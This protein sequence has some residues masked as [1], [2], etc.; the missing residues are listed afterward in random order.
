VEREILKDESLEA[1]ELINEIDTLAIIKKADDI[2]KKEDSL[3]IKVILTIISMIFIAF[4]LVTIY[5]GGFK[6]F[7]ITEALIMWVS[8][9]F[10]FTLMKKY[11]V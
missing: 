1:L 10:L 5:I 11:Y 2:S 3:R 6:W 7:L 8:P 9:V 4:S